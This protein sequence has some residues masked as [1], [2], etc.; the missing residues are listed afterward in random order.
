MMWDGARTALLGIAVIVGLAGSARAEPMPSDLQ[1][2]SFAVEQVTEASDG[3]RIA[4]AQKALGTVRT[5]LIAL[6]RTFI[7]ETLAP[8]E[9]QVGH[10]DKAL[11]AKD[12][13]LAGT[14]ADALA[15]RIAALSE[16]YI[17]ESH[18]LILRIATSL[19]TVMRECRRKNKPLAQKAFELVAADFAKL[20]PVA[21]Q[22]LPKETEILGRAL[23]SARKNIAEDSLI[24]AR[25]AINDASESLTRL[26]SI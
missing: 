19:R 7:S 4:D 2:L 21:I 1:S 15:Y 13:Y 10:I 3:G 14:T 17:G 20:R 6:K 23:E 26:S 16:S 18:T 9:E 11:A 12:A 22:K 8:L 5:S 25:R 24:S